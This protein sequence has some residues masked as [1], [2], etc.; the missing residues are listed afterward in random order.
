MLPSADGF[1]T[2]DADGYMTLAESSVNEK[3]RACTILIELGD[4][5]VRAGYSREAALP[6]ESID[7]VEQLPPRFQDLT[8][9]LLFARRVLMKSNINYS[10]TSEPYQLPTVEVSRIEHRVLDKEEKSLDL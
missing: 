10:S 8:I 1:D 6:V 9:C 7:T 2:P 5:S 3:A 4:V